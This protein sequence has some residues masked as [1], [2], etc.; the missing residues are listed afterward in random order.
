MM[1]V[2]EELHLRRNVLTSVAAAAAAGVVVVVVV[3]ECFSSCEILVEETGS[4]SHIE[5]WHHHHFG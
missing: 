4:E 2:G 5:T 1:M 3:V